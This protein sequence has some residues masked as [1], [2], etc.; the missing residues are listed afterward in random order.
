M[1]ILGVIFQCNLSVTMQVDP[2]G[3]AR[4]PDYVRT[5]HVEAPRVKWSTTVRAHP[6]HFHGQA[7]ICVSFVVES[8]VDASGLETDC[9]RSVNKA[10]RGG[11]LPKRHTFHLLRSIVIQR[12]CSRCLRDSLI[13]TPSMSSII[14]Y[15]QLQ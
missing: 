15:H 11:F 2:I 4:S 8:P 1:N 13:G 10:L 14:C 12:S 6:S 9:H 7:D 3:S 5:R